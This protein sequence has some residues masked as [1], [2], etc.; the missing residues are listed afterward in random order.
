MRILELGGDLRDITN[1]ESAEGLELNQ[2]GDALEIR[3]QG[4]KSRLLLV[5][6]VVVGLHL[7]ICIVVK[8]C[9]FCAGFPSSVG[10]WYVFVGKMNN[11]DDS[12]VCFGFVGN[13][14]KSLQ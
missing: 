3:L 1:L 7:F 12:H 14:F 8:V 4:P 13:A 6:V 11:I 9:V 5:E 2:S 10:T